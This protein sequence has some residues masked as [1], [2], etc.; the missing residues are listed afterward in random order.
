M[1]RKFSFLITLAV[2]GLA[3]SVTAGGTESDTLRWEDDSSPFLLQFHRGAIT[4]LKR[5]NDTFDTD[6][7]LEDKRFGDV[8]IRYRKPGEDWTTL[9]T[10]QQAGKGEL[11]FE[12]DAD[13]QKY[14]AVT[15]NS[16]LSL[17]LT[18][19]IVDRELLWDLQLVSKS[20]KALEIGDVVLPFPMNH[21]WNWDRE[22]TYNERVVRHSMV[23]G[24]NSFMFWMR[25]NSEPP[26]LLMTPVEDTKLEYYDHSTENEDGRSIY[27]AYV[28][29]KAQEEVIRE[30]DGSWRLPQTSFVLEPDERWNSGFKFQWASDYDEIR[31][32]LY[33]EGLFDIEIAPG[34]TV[35]EGLPVKIALKN[36]DTI[37]SIEAEYPAET[38][39]THVRTNDDGAHIYEVDFNKLGEN[40]LTVNY[41]DGRLHY[42][43]FFVTEPIETLIKKRGKFL[44]ER[45]Q[46]V[47]SDKWYDGLLSDWNMKDE[48]LLTP[49]DIHDI[50]EG[51]RYMVSSD[52]PALS[53]PSFLAKK[54]VA[55]PD[56]DEVDALDYY[57]ENFVWGGL[58]M[59]S[60]EA[61]PYAIYGIHDWKSNRE[62]SNT[63]H[64]G[65]LHIWRIYDYPHIVQMYLS[66]YRVA[67]YHEH[68]ETDLPADE[69][70][71]RAFRTAI[72]FFTYPEEVI[73]WSPY[74]TGNYNELAIV[75]VIEELEQA[76]RGIQAK[77]LRH[78]WE[79]KVDYFLSGEANLFGSEYPYDTTGFESTHAFARYAM[80]IA[81]RST[82]ERDIITLQTTREEALDFMDRQ[83]QLNVGTR[84]WLEKSYY[85]Y[86]S[87]YRGSGSASYTL[88]YMAQMGGWSLLDYALYFDDDPD[89]YL[90][91]AYGSILSSWALMNTGTEESNYGYWFPGEINDGGAGGGFEPLAYGR[92]WLQQPHGRGSWYY[93][94][95]IDLGFTGYLRA[96]ATVLSDDP[97]FGLTAFGGIL[98]QNGDEVRV[99]PKD[100]VRRR[101]HILRDNQHF[102]LRLQYDRL[103]SDEP[104]TVD[105]SLS[106]ISFTLENAGSETHESKMY[107]SGLQKGIYAVSV[108][109]EKVSE[110]TLENQNTREGIDLT[111]SSEFH[112]VDIELM[113]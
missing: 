45:Q 22:V 91:L 101:F 64:Y 107:L 34:M 90:K 68:V 26:Y 39:I 59:T 75:D 5:Q 76:G 42:L 80:A 86:G 36:R 44:T 2:F 70:L 108:D 10:S 67:R 13:S 112:Q 4:S 49:D 89:Q 58:Q 102:H 33:K 110:I 48:L 25:P 104:I 16:E 87:D 27:T 103:A 66:M 60:E 96:A 95:E 93:G 12:W 30:N 83:I 20:D 32:K 54:N 15:E 97:V 52:D 35:P 84:G 50:P 46:I 37:N 56:Q 28:H 38:Q 98:E 74:Q 6:Y 19:S 81:G 8:I 69:Y 92:N 73:G 51:R 53:R 85:L 61:Y 109:G 3:S 77:R 9:S 47:D 31:N 55:H 71:E 99:I 105:Q 14:T 40:K 88:S 78:H 65:Q 72:A 106:R 111:V 57:I 113:D 63:G 11:K 1:F 41:S 82:N 7:I 100:G 43:E 24:H 23:S 21:D 18:F 29:S 79:T 94:C 17:V 62:S